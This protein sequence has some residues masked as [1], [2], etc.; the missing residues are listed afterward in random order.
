MK[1]DIESAI[2]YAVEE[3]EKVYIDTEGNLDKALRAACNELIADLAVNTRAKPLP[4]AS[5]V[6]GCNTPTELGKLPSVRYELSN[7]A[8]PTPPAT[9]PDNKEVGE[10]VD[11]AIEE[12]E[13]FLKRNYLYADDKELT[14]GAKLL[15]QGL[16]IKELEE[17]IKALTSQPPAT[18]DDVVERVA[19]IICLTEG[20][21]AAKTI[22]HKYPDKE[23]LVIAIKSS[24][25]ERWPM[26]I[27][28]AK[29]A[30]TTLQTPNPNGDK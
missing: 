19:R 2:E 6:F 9:L 22:E 7:N 17:Q 1:S 4:D 18:G 5:I 26:Y 21:E 23:R 20:M 12:H 28:H 8:C 10:S 13:D 14:Q 15:K 25:E 16:R 3:G 11:K 24:S 27:A 29:A 30:I